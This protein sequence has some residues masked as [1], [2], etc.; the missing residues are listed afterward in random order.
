M[1]CKDCE[2]YIPIATP[3]HGVCSLPESH[4]PTEAENDCSYMVVDKLTCKDCYRFEKDFACM[5]ADKD[6]DVDGC[7][8]F[9]DI[10]EETLNN[11]FWEWLLRGK[12]SRKKIMAL[13]DKFEDNDV[14]RFIVS[15]LDNETK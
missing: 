6:D 12:Y 4:F 7:G 9:I 13:C 8:G 15:K 14:Y 1:K 10:K 11:I 2:K 5:G 3:G